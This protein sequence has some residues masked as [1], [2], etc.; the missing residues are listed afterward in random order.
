M[1]QSSG[2]ERERFASLFHLQKFEMAEV[3]REIGYFPHYLSKNFS[4]SMNVTLKIQRDTL[5]TLSFKQG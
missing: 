3:A 4:A 5:V 2:E 1:K